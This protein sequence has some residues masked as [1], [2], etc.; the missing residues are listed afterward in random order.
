MK[1]KLV[2]VVLVL[3][4]TFLN[5][6]AQDCNPTLKEIYDIPVGSTFQ[7][8]FHVASFGLGDI[9]DSST[10][11][12]KYKII[13]KTVQNDTIMLVRQGISTGY[14]IIPPFGEKGFI[15][16]KEIND[17]L[18]IVDSSSHYL[19]ACDSQLVYLGLE[20]NYS[21]ALIEEYEEQ[22]TKRVGGFINGRNNLFEYDE[23]DSLIE[24]NGF[25]YEQIFIKGVG[26]WQENWHPF[27]HSET[28]TLEGY[29]INGDTT[30]LIWDDSDFIVSSSK[31]LSSTN[32]K[33]YPNLLSDN[34]LISIS[35][36]IDYKRIEVYSINGKPQNISFVSNNQI[37]LTD[38]KAGIYII[39]L[40][41]DKY[42]ISNKIIKL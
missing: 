19:N 9:E 40:Y 7:Y 10:R 28:M 16:S 14:S 31:H 17:T 38:A 24:V 22:L 6:I 42:T 15:F 21:R 20:N 12:D 1:R 11:T 32:I 18:W 33:I 35:S 8:R 27:E 39:K 23:N 37:K 5:I 41:F 13:E 3:F 4:Y 26:L 29:V 25:E 2:L 30:G 34:E 36:D